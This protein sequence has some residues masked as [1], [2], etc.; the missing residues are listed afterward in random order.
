[1]N[2]RT[3][4]I[5]PG[6]YRFS[7]FV[8]EIAAPHG[9]TFNQY[10]IEA[11]QPLLFHCGPRAMFESVAAAVSRIMPVGQLR[12]ISFG[13]VESDECGAM[14]QWLRAAPAAQ[15][16]HGA[17]ACMVSL[18]DLADRPPRMLRDGERIDL[19][20]KS[21]VWLDTPHVPHSWE[22]GLMYE[23]TTRTLLCGDLFAHVGDGPAVTGQ[24]IVEPAIGAEEMFKATALTPMTGPTIRKLAQLGPK[25]L[26][27][28]HGSCF[29]GDCADALLKLAAY[30][31]S[32]L[33]T[34]S[35]G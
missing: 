29:E 17:T 27:V 3:D 24:S 19:G 9:F 16:V 15:V 6:I 25:R 14:N 32:A 18:N 34:V 20:G 35:P 13:H 33:G 30:Y 8:P 7:T 23:E 11:G 4:E 22:S 31:E 10:L 26:A 21:V 2:V 28:M 1:M 12:W 5:T